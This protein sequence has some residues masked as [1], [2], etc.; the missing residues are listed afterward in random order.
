MRKTNKKGFTIVELVIVIAVIAILAAVLIPTYSSLVKK[1]N[2]SA[3]IQAVKNMN[4]FLAAAKYTDGVDSILDVYD[5]FEES[6][7]SVESY[8]P[9][10][11]GRSFYY[12][13]EDNMIVY[14]EDGKVIYPKLD[15]D[16]QGSKS[17]LSLDMNGVTGT[18]PSTYTLNN[19]ELSATVESAAEYKY[20]I[21]AFNKNTSLTKLELT[22]MGEIDMMGA[23]CTIK[24]IKN[25]QTVTIKGTNNAVLKNVTSV[26]TFSTS[27][28]NS[29]KVQADYN[30]SGLIAKNCGTLRIESIT[31][32][33]LNVRTIMGGNV[34]ILV[35]CSNNDVT[36]NT[37]TIKNSTVIGHRN[38][39]ALVGYQDAATVII[40]GNN[41][42]NNVSVKTTGG[43]SALYIGL[44]TGSAKL[45]VDSDASITNTNSTLS[46]YEC[47]SSEQT[48][49][50]I[51][52]FS[53][54]IKSFKAY[55]DNGEKEYSTYPFFENALVLVLQGKSNDD[56]NYK[57][58]TSLA[59]IDNISS[60]FTQPN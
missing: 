35:G 2:E 60:L 29:Q 27:T 49:T 58:F 15:S 3:D 33:N 19:N 23:S 10:Y 4:T 13:K 21:D 18:Q 42:L 57:V 12:S 31:F 47:A 20:V 48:F 38:V 11:K 46:I 52:T 22:I 41:E 8:A 28:N 53:E 30:A 40:S 36:I 34:G 17:W 59:S 54:Y 50:K 5:V 14:A 1:A 56:S 24:E 26:E 37:V 16:V 43:K 45:T 6:D 51:D 7:Y 32:E 39:G 44:M 9:L 25:G 55:K